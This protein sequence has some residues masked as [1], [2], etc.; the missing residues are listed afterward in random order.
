MSSAENYFITT[1]I[2]YVNDVPHIGHAYTEVA[3]D[4]L[5]RW[6]RQNGKNAWLL[7]G[8]DEHGQKILRT[9]TANGVT[10]KEWADKLVAD[11]WLPLLDTIT[12]HNDDFIRTTDE[13][14]EVAVSKFL[15]KLKD[16]GFIYSGEYEG[17]YC[18]GCEE[19]KQ[20]GDLLDGGDDFPGEKVCAIHTRPIE[21]LKESNYFF[22]MSDFQQKLLD[23][24][25]SQPDFIQPESVRNE[26]ISF[27][28][29]GLDDLSI[30]RATFDW[31]VKIPWDDS[32]V[33][34]VWFDA[35]LNY[36]SATGWGSDD[37]EFAQRWPAIHIV[38][39]D[40]ARF[41]AVIWPAMLMAAGLQPPRR[42]FGHGWLLV[43]GE[44]MSKSKLTGI[45]PH[46]ITDVFGADA[47]RYYFM[48]AINFGQDGSFSWE[49]LAARYQAEL[50]NGFGNLASR[51]I[52]MVNRY[53][54]DVVPAA[55]ELNDA[56]AVIV[57]T[58][59][60]AFDTANIAID[61]LAIHDAINAV[62]TIVDA[63]NLYITEQEPWVL[64]KDDANR[65][66][67]HTVLY[68]AVE[69]L[70]AIAV[71]LS[72]VMPT[73]TQKLWDALGLGDALGALTD[74][75]LSR[76]GQWGIAPAGI[77]VSSLDSLFPR[78]EE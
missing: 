67:L 38:G 77:R 64:A 68:T 30:S 27:V 29:R 44:K 41:H 4:V 53:C 8:T 56:D 58:V 26:I 10:P 63:L 69:G 22:R 37:D 7:T 61:R 40:I 76:A 73:A 20:P 31:G 5:A 49:D 6:N 42:V 28:K 21:T 33:V 46:Q 15:Q 62:W 75:H 32:H 3:A 13:R 51:V 74:Q 54:N 71:G 78:I 43:G 59:S 11:A 35:L 23:L 9:S 57:D 39:K 47:F 14:H 48:S 50:A 19:Y 60:R 12:I 36:I 34:Y 2:F 24:Y 1:P 16:D 52:A 18:V 72:P 70:R 17:F 25:E 55:T 45:A 65:D 66:R